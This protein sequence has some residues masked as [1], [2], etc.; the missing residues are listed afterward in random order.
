MSFVL[1]T[2]NAAGL[3]PRTARHIA[4]KNVLTFIYKHVLNSNGNWYVYRHTVF[5]VVP[6]VT[7]LVIT[8]AVYFF[9]GLPVSYTHL[10]LPTIYSV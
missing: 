6:V 10:T 1:D 4:C 5:L 9:V 8:D 3:F 7:F 2:N